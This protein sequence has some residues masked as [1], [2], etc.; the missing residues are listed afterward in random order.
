MQTSSSKNEV[1]IKVCLVRSKDAFCLL[2]DTPADAKVKIMH[3]SLFVCKTKI[4]PSVFLAHAEALQNSTA[5]YQ[6]KRTVCKALAIPQKFSRRDIRES[7]FGSASDASGR[8]ARIQLGVQRKQ[9]SQSVQLSALQPIGD[10][11]LS[12]RS[13]AAR[14]E[15]DSAE[16]RWKP[17][18]TRIQLNVLRYGQTE[19]RQRQRHIA[20]RLQRRL[21]SIRIRPDCRSLRRRP[22]QPGETFASR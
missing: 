1:G 16:L 15:A 3:A 6:I 7:H 12:G 20:R 13:A 5:K 10:R 14:A 22:L 11:R 8:R 19:L 18:H 2:G 9:T 17:I 21:R 4:S